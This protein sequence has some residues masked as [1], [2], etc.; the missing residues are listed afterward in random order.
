MVKKG[1]AQT[2]FSGL[3]FVLLISVRL[4]QAKLSRGE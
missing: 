1:K 4:R 2:V 3:R